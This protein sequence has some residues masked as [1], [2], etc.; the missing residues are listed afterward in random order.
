[1]TIWLFPFN[2]LKGSMI[3]RCFH[4][5]LNRFKIIL[6]LSFNT[7]VDSLC[8]LN[9]IIK[10]FFRWKTSF[11][12]LAINSFIA[13]NLIDEDCK[14][15]RLGIA[16]LFQLLRVEIYLILYYIKKLIDKYI[17]NWY[18]SG[19]IKRILQFAISNFSRC[20]IFYKI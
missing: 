17:L 3:L 18:N 9:T 16:S 12:Y 15:F 7:P 14:K 2:R 6:Q 5:R 20:Y 13:S 19:W 10:R 11:A 4:T 1:M 8:S